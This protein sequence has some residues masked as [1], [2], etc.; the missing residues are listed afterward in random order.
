MSMN[1]AA[2]RQREITGRVVL[3]CFISFFA[4][5][6]SVNAVMIRFAV[7]TFAG[8]ETES[9]YRAG[10]SYNSEQAAA[11]S[12]DALRWNVEGG[13]ARG[14]SGEAVLTIDVKD[15][16]QTPVSQIEV[17][18]RLA[19]PLNSRLD[20]R[21]TLSRTSSGSFQGATD[22]EP[23][24]WTLT[25]DILRNDARVYRSVSRLVLK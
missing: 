7:T 25:L 21:I 20:R 2:P 17:S 12:Q 4:V 3:I 14:R 19:H 24:Q 5:V 10:L 15:S 1:S 16:R 8:T 13:F 11:V 6:A 22:A 9:S 23:G 18:A